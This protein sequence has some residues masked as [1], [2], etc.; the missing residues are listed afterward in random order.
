MLVYTDAVTESRIASGKVS[1]LKWIEFSN[2]EPISRKCYNFAQSMQFFDTSKE[3]LND[4]TIQI[5]DQL[6]RFVRLS[7]PIRIILHVIHP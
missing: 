3:V 7:Q 5:R 1:V 6:G 2:L 4:I